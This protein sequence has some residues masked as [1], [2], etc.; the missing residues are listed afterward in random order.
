MKRISEPNVLPLMSPEP[1]PVRPGP[2]DRLARP[3]RDL[4]LSVLDRCNLRCTY[5]MPEDSLQ[6][7]GVFLPREQ[8]L[9]DDEL[10][11]LVRVFTQLGVNKIRLTGGEP[12]LRPGFSALVRRIAA[13][14][15]I[16]DLA[17]TTNGILL[18]RHAESLHRA[19][20]GRITVSL[21]SLDESAFRALSGHR[22][23]V[24]EVLDGIT[25][26][27]AAGFR[28]LK[29]N[30][31]VQRGVND[32]GIEDMVDHFRGTGHVLRFIEFMDVG[33]L[34]H[35]D[36]G[37][38]VPSAEL[39]ARIHARWP[40]RPLEPGA[41]GETA[42]RYGFEDGKGEIGFISSITQPFCGDCTRARVTADGNFYTCLFASQGAALKP[43]L[44]QGGD[45]A[46]RAFLEQRWP[47][48]QDRYS[49][50]RSRS[51]MPETGQDDSGDAPRVEM[52]RMGG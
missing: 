4:R 20:L 18:P 25:A 13:E 48:R 26:A 40:L 28:S 23:S 38:V 37:Q 51:V 42:R 29:I 34:N 45:E 6:G 7:Q 15:R 1:D 47:R 41:P 11:R 17:L 39:L 10:V 33:N 35:W 16:D 36:R 21:D 12:L 5:C 46:L 27:E 31:V 8:V 43:L 44:R 30:C 2:V 49:E 9:T 50:I 22:G 32:A 3:L 24:G 52:F 19:G 14:P